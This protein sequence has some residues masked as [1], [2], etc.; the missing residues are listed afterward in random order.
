MTIEGMES[1]YRDDTEMTVREKFAGQALKGLL[2]NPTSYLFDLEGMVAKA[3]VAADL[4]I[5]ELEK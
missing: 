3:V 2:S 1:P 4:L 5:K